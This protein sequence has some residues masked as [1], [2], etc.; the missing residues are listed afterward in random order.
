ME[1]LKVFFATKGDDLLHFLWLIVL[2][3]IIILVGKKVI[4]VLLNFLKRCF[5]RAEMELGIQGF[6]LTLIKLGLYLLLA[7]V[8][9]EVIGIGAGSIIAVIG[10]AGLALGL[11]LQGSLSNLAGGVLILLTKPFV[12]GDFIVVG[13]ESGTVKSIDIFYTKIITADN[14]VIVMPNGTLSN[15]NITNNTSLPVRRIDILV[16][17]AYEEEIEKVKKLLYNLA[18]REE[19]I[20]QDMEIQVYVNNFDPSAISMGLRFWVEKEVYWNVKWDMMER[21]K[22]AF[23]ENG[24]TIPFDQLDVNLVRVTE[25]QTGEQQ[26]KN[27]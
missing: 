21:I 11:A 12:V 9:T 20:Q 16:S 6:L 24:I 4:K 13:A 18:V 7:M 2:A 15:S 10:S 22:K 19:R 26:E 25:K 5:E 8:I 3:V 27:G 1:E 14:R 23:D 17:I